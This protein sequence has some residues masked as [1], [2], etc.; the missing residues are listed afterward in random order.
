MLIDL[1][2]TSNYVSYNIKLAQLLGLKEAIYLSELLNINDKAIR[3]NKINNNYFDIDRKYIETRTTLN[4]SEQDKIE[5]TLIKLKIIK[6]QEDSIT[7]DLNVIIALLTTE[8]TET[9]IK[10]KPRTQAQSKLVGQANALKKYLKCTNVELFNAFSTWIETILEKQGW[11]SKASVE[12]GEKLVDEIS[13]HDLDIA[14]GI[15]NIASINGYRDMTWAVK[16]W[17]DNYKISYN[18]PIQNKKGKEKVELSSEE[19]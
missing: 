2:N 9:I 7:I 1:I 6:K 10:P 11:M 14:L 3:K 5:K 15:V 8:N 16:K 4:V 18:K 17:Q 19:F 12:E 13:N